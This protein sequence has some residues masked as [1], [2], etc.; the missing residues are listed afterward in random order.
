MCRSVWRE[1]NNLVFFVVF[2]FQRFCLTKATPRNLSPLSGDNE[3][4][5]ILSKKMSA[6]YHDMTESLNSQSLA[7]VFHHHV[8]PAWEPGMCSRAIFLL[9]KHCYKE[10]V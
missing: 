7:S 5:S 4:S 8:F 10:A 1:L 2:F 3:I 6:E 9:H